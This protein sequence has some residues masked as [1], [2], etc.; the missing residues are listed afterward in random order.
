MYVNSASNPFLW[1]RRK[2][3]LGPDW[4]RIP[5]CQTKGMA[6]LVSGLPAEIT[7]WTGM[8]KLT[9]HGLAEANRMVPSSTI[10][11]ARINNSR[12]ELE[13]GKKSHNHR[14]RSGSCTISKNEVRTSI[15]EYR[16]VCQACT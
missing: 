10:L 12:K 3:N 2:P 6:H 9:L 13:E 11:L 5:P 14:V 7:E 1:L 4:H 16:N 15:R 8:I